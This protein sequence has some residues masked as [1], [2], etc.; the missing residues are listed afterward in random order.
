[1]GT[2][3][4]II[5]LLRATPEVSL[6]FKVTCIAP[7]TTLE[8]LEL[9]AALRNDED[10]KLATE[11]LL[12]TEELS[13]GTELNRRELCSELACSDD[14]LGIIDDLGNADDLGMA[15]ELAIT[16]DLTIAEDTTPALDLTV[17]AELRLTALT[18]LFDEGFSLEGLTEELFVLLS[19]VTLE[20][21]ELLLLSGLV[22]PPPHA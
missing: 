10:C 12:I 15:D 16:E 11:D 22:A 2:P 18:E 20:L 14:A 21:L 19:V 8:R 9:T 13:T 6:T 5:S 4:R 3:L 17:P 1:M 7:E